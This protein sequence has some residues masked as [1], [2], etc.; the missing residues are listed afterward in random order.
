MTTTT[1][2]KPQHKK[3]KSKRINIS[4][5]KDDLY[6]IELLAQRDNVPVTTK[7]L[8]LIEMALEWEED[9]YLCDIVKERLKKNEGKEVKYISHEDIWEK[10]IS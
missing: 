4:P 3:Y 7:A 2:E 5:K 1:L 8:E 10:H 9:I 6:F